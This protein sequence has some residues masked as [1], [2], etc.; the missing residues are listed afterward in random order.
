MALGRRTLVQC[1]LNAWVLRVLSPV[2]AG[3]AKFL[4]EMRLALELPGL[5]G[6]SA[7]RPAGRLEL[8]DGSTWSPKS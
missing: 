1:L 6:F 7:R 2:P 4:P 5:M 8:A 3:R